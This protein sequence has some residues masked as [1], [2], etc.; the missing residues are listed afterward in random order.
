MRTGIAFENR[1]ITIPIHERII[2]MGPQKGLVNRYMLI[3]GK[4]HTIS[5]GDT[6]YLENY[7]FYTDKYGDHVYLISS[8]NH[9]TMN[10]MPP[11]IRVN[12]IEITFAED[13][14]VYTDN[15]TIPDELIETFARKILETKHDNTL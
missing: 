1:F 7:R 15:L 9:S 3:D 5:I 13:G 14:T 11:G 12:I 8:H 4:V 10:N 6:V 2:D